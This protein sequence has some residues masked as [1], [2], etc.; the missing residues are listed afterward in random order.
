MFRTVYYDT[1]TLDNPKKREKYDPLVIPERVVCP[2]CG[3]ID[4]YELGAMG[5]I[6]I[7]A[8]MMAEVAPEGKSMLR[9]DQRV[10]IRQLHNSLGTD[11]S[12]GGHRALRA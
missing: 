4:Q 6:A 2:K 1:L 11:A 5:H 9:E 3:A 10:Q 7:T 8:S 12:Q